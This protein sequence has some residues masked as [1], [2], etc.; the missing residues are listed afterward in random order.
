MEANEFKRTLLPLHPLLYRIALRITDN[1]EDAED[2]VQETY[3]RLWR[4][5]DRLGKADNAEGYAVTTLRHVCY[6]A[7][8]SRPPDVMVR[9]LDPAIRDTL[10]ADDN[11]ADMDRREEAEIVM[12]IIGSLPSP[13]R[14]VVT[15]RDVEDRPFD[16]IAQ[17]TGLK[18]GYVRVTLFR[19]RQ[20]IRELFKRRTHERE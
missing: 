13:Q 10:P 18:E 14:E 12:E 4:Q 7:L 8:S 6:D 9:Q 15:M 5:R 1:R 20:Q 3:V 17:S 16:E 11:V 2:L 19:A